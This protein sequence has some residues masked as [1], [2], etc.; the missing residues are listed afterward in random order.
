MYVH[1]QGLRRRGIKP[2]TRNDALSR[3]AFCQFEG[4]GIPEGFSPLNGWP[5]RLADDN[6]PGRSTTTILAGRKREEVLC[7]AGSGLALDGLWL[8]T[9]SL[10][11][12]TRKQSLLSSPAASGRRDRFRSS[13]NQEL[14]A[15]PLSAFCGGLSASDAAVER[16]LSPRFGDGN[17]PRRDAQPALQ[18]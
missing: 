2:S 13:G 18:A 16:A 5:T 17:P 8:S 14:L 3:F 12:G 11:M 6:Y 7:R 9:F 15:R 10:Y 4:M 1:A